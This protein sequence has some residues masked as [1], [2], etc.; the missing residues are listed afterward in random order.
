MFPQM[1]CDFFVL[2][3]CVAIAVMTLMQY[4]QRLQ[5]YLSVWRQSA[6]ACAFFMTQLS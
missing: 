4:F 1:G 5:F 3:F 6:A 2:P